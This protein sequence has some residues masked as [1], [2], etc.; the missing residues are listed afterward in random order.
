MPEFFPPQ[1]HIHLLSRALL[2]KGNS[3][4]LCRV[5]GNDWFFLPGGHV[6]D[7]ESLRKALMRELEEELGVGD[8]EILFPIGACENIFTRKDDS[9]YHEFNVIFEAKL[10][11]DAAVVSKEPHLEFIEIN[12]M[13]VERYEIRPEAVKTGIIGWLVDKKPFFREL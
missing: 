8:C 10:S 11:E 6:E 3:I 5:K 13:D 1:S 9:L 2:V 12:R 4:I 7:G